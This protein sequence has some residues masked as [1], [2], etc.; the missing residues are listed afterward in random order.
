MK[1]LA[2]DGP[3]RGTLRDV[4]SH[5]F[6]SVVSSIDNILSG[7]IQET[8]YHVHKFLLCGRLIRI[9]STHMMPDQISDIDVFEAI[10]SPNAKDAAE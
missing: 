6:L 1:V 4:K 9:A 7:D 3:A 2:I 8:T 5:R 10:A